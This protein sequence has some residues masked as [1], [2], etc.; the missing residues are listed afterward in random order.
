VRALVARA[1]AG[2]LRLVR[3]EARPQGDHA[4]IDGRALEADHVVWACGGW[5]AALFAEHVQLRVTRQEVV[6][7]DVPQQWASPP[8]PAWIDFDASLY[9]HALIEPHGMKVASDR[10]GEPV[11]PGLRPAEAG[12]PSVPAAREY[13]AIRF[14]AL[15]GA[16]VRS[17]PGCHYSLTPDGNFIFARHPEHERV[18]LLGGGSGHGFKHG[19]A[20]AEQAARVL[21][22]V[23]QP[24]ARFALAERVRSG[25]LRTAG[26]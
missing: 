2:G 21:A 10:E 16:P 13:L 12:E 19:P 6:L 15:A 11:E 25:A 20:I 22:G 23:A 26:S 5:L 18:W 3:G 7:F 4:V 1:R 8:A 17:A 9:G 14:P 24:D